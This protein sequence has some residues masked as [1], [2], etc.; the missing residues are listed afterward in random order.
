MENTLIFLGNKENLRKVE[1][2]CKAY[3]LKWY[4]HFDFNS[5]NVLYDNIGYNTVFMVNGNVIKI[6]DFGFSHQPYFKN[7]KRYHASNI[8]VDTIVYLDQDK[9]FHAKIID[10]YVLCTIDYIGDSAKE[11]VNLIT[12]S[13]NDCVLDLRFDVASFISYYKDKLTLA[14]LE[15]ITGIAQGQLSHYLNGTSKPSKATR[16]KFANAIHEFGETLKNVELE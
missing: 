1:K 3:N 16:E 7:Y 15:R 2:F 4:C 12:K 13:E 14:G 10:K 11:V 6:I 8:M 5:K 9:R